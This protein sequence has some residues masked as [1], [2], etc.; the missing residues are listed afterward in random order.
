MSKHKYTAAAAAAKGLFMA[1]KNSSLLMDNRKNPLQTLFKFF[2]PSLGG[3]R[4]PQE[5]SN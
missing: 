3:S 4:K 5:L 1:I 2:L